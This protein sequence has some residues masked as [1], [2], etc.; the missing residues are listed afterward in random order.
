LNTCMNADPAVVESTSLSLKLR[1]NCT[2]GETS[3]PKVAVAITH[4]G[5][6]QGPVAVVVVTLVVDVVPVV[7]G[8]MSITDA[9]PV[10]V[11]AVPVTAMTVVPPG[12]ALET[13]RVSTEVTLLPAGGVTGLVLKTPLTPDGSVGTARVTGELKLP[14]DCTVI[15]VVPTPP[16]LIVSV[17]GLADMVNDAAVVGEVAVV[18]VVVVPVAVNGNVAESSGPKFDIAVTV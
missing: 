1:R 11:P 9:E 18:V 6:V 12:A 16:G 2:A 17:P 4:L 10:R 3:D 7:V 5:G 14:I 15:V 8:M 13:A